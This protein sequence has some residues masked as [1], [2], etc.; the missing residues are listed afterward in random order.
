MVL[1][2]DRKLVDYVNGIMRNCLGPPYKNKSPVCTCKACGAIK[3]ENTANNP[4]SW[5]PGLPSFLSLGRHTETAVFVLFKCRN[6]YSDYKNRND[7]TRTGTVWKAAGAQL[8]QMLCSPD[9][10]RNV[11]QRKHFGVTPR[12]FFKVYLWSKYFN[13]RKERRPS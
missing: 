4:Q 5:K 1:K 13:G 9:R 7:C 8:K 11:R 12:L 6:V 10:R 3:M 2:G